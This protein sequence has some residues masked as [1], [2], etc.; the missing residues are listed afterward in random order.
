M[1]VGVALYEFCKRRWVQIEHVKCL[2]PLS[3]GLFEEEMR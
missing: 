3:I 2:H 1:I